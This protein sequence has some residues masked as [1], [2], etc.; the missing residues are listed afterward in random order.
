MS[1]FINSFQKLKS[2]CEAE[3]YAGWDP[4]DGLNSKIFQLK[5]KY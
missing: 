3:N 2:Y 1:N 4:Y 5:F